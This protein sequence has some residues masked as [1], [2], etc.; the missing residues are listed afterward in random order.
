MSTQPNPIR[1]FVPH[2]VTM[3]GIMQYEDTQSTPYVQRDWSQ[4]K[5][6]KPSEYVSN[7]PISL[8]SWGDIE[9]QTENTQSED[10]FMQRAW[11][12]LD[13]FVRQRDRLEPP[14]SNSPTRGVVWLEERDI[15]KSDLNSLWFFVVHGSRR[16]PVE[17]VNALEDLQNAP[18][19]A[20]EEGFPAPSDIAVENADRLLREM[21]RIS[22]RRFEVHPTPDGE[23]AIDAPGGRGRSVLLLC[24]SEGGALCLVNMNGNHRRAR[25][26]TT[27]RLPDGFVREALAELEH[28][29]DQAR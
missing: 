6:T 27:E 10:H 11:S 2:P 8:S 13:H 29:S 16:F 4:L 20:N 14:D 21:Y 7:S 1:T 9:Y 19:E 15:T 17:L 3:S 22:P 18:D 24:D 26:S 23:I 12:I 28:E 5:P 25:Y